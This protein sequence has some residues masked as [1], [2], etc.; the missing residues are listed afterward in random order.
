MLLC[1]E[2]KSQRDKRIA[3]VRRTAERANKMQRALEDISEVNAYEAFILNDIER[4]RRG[5][6]PTDPPPAPP[7]CMV[8]DQEENVDME[9]SPQAP[10][11][12]EY[13]ETQGA[14]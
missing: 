11:A 3:E 14:A 9:M 8:E 5:E 7:A 6:H 10:N 13:F 4:M 1:A 2:T 12:Y